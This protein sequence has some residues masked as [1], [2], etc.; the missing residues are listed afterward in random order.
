[1]HALPRGSKVPWHRILGS[2]GRISLPGP[3]G[4]RQRELLEA[5]RIRFNPAGKIDLK[6][7]RWKNTS[8]KES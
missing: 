3:A 4:R 6:K 8:R 1:M 5:E 2:T 7:Y